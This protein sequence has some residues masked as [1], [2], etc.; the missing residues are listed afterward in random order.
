[1]SAQPA[2]THNLRTLH[3]LLR[4]ANTTLAASLRRLVVLLAL[5]AAPR[6]AGRA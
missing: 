4:A 5:P 2:K 1:M 6:L 3:D